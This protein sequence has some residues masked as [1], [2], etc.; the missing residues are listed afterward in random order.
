MEI[1]YYFRQQQTPMYLWQNVHFIDE[2]SHHGINIEVFNPL[3]FKNVDLANANLIG[4]LQEKKYDMFMTCHNEKLLYIDTLKEIKKLGIP[5]LLICFDNLLIPYEHKKVCAYFDLVWLTA[6]ETKHMFDRWGAKTVFSPYAANPYKYYYKV[7]DL[8]RNKMVFNGTPYGSRANM[9]NN[10]T[11]AGIPVDVYANVNNGKVVKKKHTITEYMQKMVR[12]FSFSIGRKV[13]WS[14]LKQKVRKH[15]FIKDNNSLVIRPGVEFDEISKLYSEYSLS[16]S[17]TSA[18]D[19]GILKNSVEVIVLR[20]FEIPMSG[21]I[22][23]CKYNEEL[24]RYFEEDKEII[25]Y[26]TEEEM[27]RKAKYY[28]DPKRDAERKQIRMCAR[29][30][31]ESE[32]TWMKRFELVFSELG[33][34]YKE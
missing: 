33:L 26:R 30:R 17:S 16:L 13:L 18:R 8:E 32:H 14:A 31:A 9:I 1:L 11:S 24:S 4:Q 3:N 6:I 27:I 7:A 34:L 21:G 23:F 29:K 15:S 2:L 10:I 25:F 28:L 20:C 5:N 22:L 19:T 12:F